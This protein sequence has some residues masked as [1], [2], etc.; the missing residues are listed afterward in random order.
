[1]I[2]NNASQNGEGNQAPCSHFSER[3]K[4]GGNEHFL[5]ETRNVADILLPARKKGAEG[6]KYFP[7]DRKEKPYADFLLRKKK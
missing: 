1:L 4:K 7:A 3:K 2:Q 6:G 5:T